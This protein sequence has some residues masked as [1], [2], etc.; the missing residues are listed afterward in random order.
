M[1]APQD[2][3]VKELTRKLYWAVTSSITSL[4]KQQKGSTFNWAAHLAERILSSR[5]A[6]RPPS[7]DKSPLNVDNGQADGR[8]GG[9]YDPSHTKG[10]PPLPDP[11]KQ[12]AWE[13]DQEEKRRK[14]WEYVLQSREGVQL[15]I[16]SSAYREVTNGRSYSSGEV[17]RDVPGAV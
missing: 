13:R 4:N 1:A 9:R 3:A 17:G 6:F 10:R 12:Q 2:P 7:V 11:A 5:V 14:A 8:G 16:P 15:P